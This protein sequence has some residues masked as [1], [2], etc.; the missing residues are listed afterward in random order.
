MKKRLLALMLAASMVFGLTACGSSSTGSASSEASES[1]TS[2]DGAST[3]STVVI[4]MGSGFDTLDPGQVYE[5]YP[6]MVINACYETLFK[7]YSNDGAAEPMLADTYSFNE[8]NTVLTITLKDGVTF[9]SGNPLTSKDVAFSLNRTKNLQ[10]NPAFIT[11]TIA[12]IETP[13]DKTVVINLTE[14]DGAI[15]SKLAYSA[16]SILDSEV[17]TANGGTDAEDAATSDSAQAYL[18]SA[19]AGSGMFVMTS[20]IPDSEIVLEKNP[21]YWGEATNVDKYVIKI[22]DDANTQMM[23]LSSGDIDIACN[24]TEDTMSELEGKDGITLLNNSTKTVSFLMMNMDESIG[25]PVSDPKVQQAIRLAVD[26]AGIQT[27]C[28]E[29]TTTPYSI[30]QEG[31]FGSLGERSTDYTD[32]EAAKA[33]LAE[34]GYADGFDIDLTVCDLAMEGIPLTDLAQKVASD[35]AEIGINVNIVSEAWAAGYGDDY[36]DGKLGFTVMY[37]GIDY[38]DPN[39]QLEF[40]A[41]GV[42][43][44]RAG[45]TAESDPE[46]ASLYAKATNAIE[47]ADREAVLKEIQEATYEYG[48]FVMLAQAPCPMAYNSRLTGVAFSDPY[49][50]D[51]T[52]VNVQ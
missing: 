16:C 7:F 41:G 33:L 5:K 26:Y 34:A 49:T 39:V 36:R 43:G 42:V 35:L 6:Q 2:E 48:P 27:I 40:L 3:N 47:D 20:Y 4:A 37:W 12:S 8:D 13:D 14:P 44:L 23:T 24:M 45:W 52:Q 25:G 51:L 1:A 29:G 18:D 28:G 15:L 9:A 46:I 38:N 50:V 10:G 11:D 17:V 30:I 22:Q 31:F 19:S 32:V 21:S